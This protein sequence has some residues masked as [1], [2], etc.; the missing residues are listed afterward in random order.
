[1]KLMTLTAMI[2][3]RHGTRPNAGSPRITGA[4]PCCLR[5]T[6]NGRLASDD[7]QR[8]RDVCYTLMGRHR[9]RGGSRAAS[10]LC[11]YTGPIRL[12]DRGFGLFLLNAFLPC[13]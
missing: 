6:S 12:T 5:Q 4:F 2:D 9:Q 10:G 1:M 3:A 8:W 11:E 7:C 13:F